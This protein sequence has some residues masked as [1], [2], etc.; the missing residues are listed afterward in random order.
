MGLG[1]VALSCYLILIVTGILLM[2]YYKPSTDL[3]YNSIKDIHYVVP[4]GRLMRNLHRW[5]AH[6]M[7]FSV[8]IHMAR[9]FYTASYKKTRQFNWTI[10][11]FLLILTFGLS[12]TGYL[13]PWDQLAYWAITIGANI[14]QSPQ[15]VTDTL[16]LTKYFDPGGILKVILLGSTTVGEDSLVRFNLLHVILLPVILTVLLGVHFWRIRKDGGLSRP[17]DDWLDRHLPE[18]EEEKPSFT[19]APGKTYGLMAIVKGSSPTV[20]KSPEK[21]VSTWPHLFYAELAVLMVTLVVLLVWSFAMDAPLKELANPLVPENPAKAPWY[22]LGIQ[23]L[24]SFSAFMGG[25]GIPTLAVIG[26][27]LIP[28]LDRENTGMGRWFAE[29]GEKRVAFQ[30]FVFGLLCVLLVEALAIRFGWL[31]D[32]FPGIP[33][34]FITLINPGTVLAALYALWSLQ[35]IRRTGSTRQGA[36][37]LFTCFLIGF[38]VLTVI[39]VHFRGPNWDFYWWPSLWPAAH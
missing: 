20:G 29:E 11:I 26:L 18:E 33:Q 31:R 9:V 39:G 21:T 2:F 30:S 38:L 6:L 37:A 25:V 27:M 14:A 3:A 28:Y 35:V 7:V 5:A 34:L 23:E 24:V 15:E 32:W 16:G 22:F 1:L 19:Q 36:V 10:G 8:L 17:E 4:T 13:L 12:F